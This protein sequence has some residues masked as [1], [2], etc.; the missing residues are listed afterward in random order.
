MNALKLL[1]L[2][3]LMFFVTLTES[4]AH[5]QQGSIVRH[6]VVQSSGLFEVTMVSTG[7]R[8]LKIPKNEFFFV[9]GRTLQVMGRTD[10]VATGE[11][12]FTV[13]TVRE[14][15]RLETIMHF[16]NGHPH[17]VIINGLHPGRNTVPPE[18]VPP[19]AV[20][21]ETRIS[22]NSS[23]TSRSISSPVASR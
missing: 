6:F 22:N 16:R 5:A 15:S 23:P 10:R 1:V 21:I 14:Q 3:S 2:T 8:F 18:I 19:N 7:G 20:R 17:Y 13:S 4:A 12:F 9:E 11:K